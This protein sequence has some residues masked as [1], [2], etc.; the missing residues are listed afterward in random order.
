MAALYAAV[1]MHTLGPM[2]SRPGPKVTDTLD[3]AALVPVLLKHGAN[4][5]LR[6]KKPIIAGTTIPVDASME[7]ARLP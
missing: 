3:A 1:D 7:K 4:P 6:L 2:L 5:N